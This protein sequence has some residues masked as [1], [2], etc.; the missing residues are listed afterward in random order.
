M[1]KIFICTTCLLAMLFAISPTAFADDSSQTGVR[2]S[3]TVDNV[4]GT[5]DPFIFDASP[6]VGLTVFTSDTAYSI[7][8]ANN[9]TNE[10]NGLEYGTL[11]SATGYAQRTKTTAASQGPEA[12]DSATVLPGSDWAWMGGSGS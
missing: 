1:K 9:K 7:T 6:N 4:A 12:A 8:A 11:S 10:A 3:L 5:S 2:I